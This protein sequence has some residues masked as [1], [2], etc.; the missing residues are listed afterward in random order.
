MEVVK[1][2]PTKPTPPPYEMATSPIFPYTLE[3]VSGAKAKSYPKKDVPLEDVT[4]FECRILDAAN[5]VVDVKSLATLEQFSP[6][7]NED[8]CAEYLAKE[9]AEQI[10]NALDRTSPNP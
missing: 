4:H 2:A 7:F 6:Y 8:G 3:K 9:I 10:K 5:K 1:E